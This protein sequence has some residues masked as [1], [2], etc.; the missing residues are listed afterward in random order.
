[1]IY[2]SQSNGFYL[3]KQNI[4]KKTETMLT[5]TKLIL[6][7]FQMKFHLAAKKT[8]LITQT[9]LRHSWVPEDVT[10][11]L[12]VFYSQSFCHHIFQT[13]C[14]FRFSFRF[15]ETEPECSSSWLSW[16]VVQSQ[17][18]KSRTDHSLGIHDSGYPRRPLVELFESWSYDRIH[19]ESRV[20]IELLWFPHEQQCFQDKNC[21]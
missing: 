2:I 3:S 18:C 7:F 5:L 10:F 14:K 12:E 1:M 9:K 20:L 13:T 19:L 16:S 6:W 8:K 21:D 11:M 17:T 4:H 15:F